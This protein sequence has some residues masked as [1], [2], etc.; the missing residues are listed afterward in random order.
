MNKVVC[1]MV[2]SCFLFTFG[3]KVPYLKNDPGRPL[4]DEE[5]RQKRKDA[6]AQTAAVCGLV[7]ATVAHLKTKDTKKSIFW[8]VI[9]GLGCGLFTYEY[10]KNLD[11][12]REELKGREADLDAQLKYARAVNEETKRYNE[13]TTLEIE[14]IERRVNEGEA[15]KKRLQAVEYRLEED[16]ENLSK[17]IADLQAY[18]AGVIKGKD[19]QEKQRVADL[20][21]QI[22]ELQAQLDVLENNTQKV[23]SL[24]K[25]VEV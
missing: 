9:G 23:A 19:S 16:K 1:V 17:T 5:V 2:M 15:K 20:D 3:C 25:R 10:T 11:K 12:K 8:G 21:K 24:K 4:T 7:A 6:I 18:R 22:R 14:N 13:I